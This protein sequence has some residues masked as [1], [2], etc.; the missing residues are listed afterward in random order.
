[1]LPAK[2]SPPDLPDWIVSRPRIARCIA[3]GVHDGMVTVVSGPPG[4]G[5]TV[6]LAQ[7]LRA[8]RCPGP[9]AWLTLDE[10][11]DTAGRFWW[12]V[13]AALTKSGVPL[14][15][16]MVPGD[17]DT[18][19]RIV[20]ALAAQRPPVVLVLDNLHL[21]R[22]PALDFLLSQAKPGLR[23]VAGT[24]VDHP[25]PLQR[26][27]LTW[28]ATELHG[29]QLAFTGP[30]TRLLL[31]RCGVAS[32]RESLLPLVKKTEGWAA[33]LRFVMIA[34]AGAGS[35]AGDPG[36]AERLIRGY[37]TSEVLDTQ[38]PAIRDLLLRSSFPD[39]IRP[40][41]AEALTDRADGLATLADLVQAN[42][43]LAPAENGWYRFHPLFR[44]VLQSALRESGPDMFGEVLSRTVEWF[45]RHGHLADAVRYAASTGDGQLATQVTIDE[46]AVS[47]LLDPGQ[48]RDL[49]CALQDVA[50]PSAPVR[51]REYVSAAAIALL[52]HDHAAAASWLARAD[53]ALRGLASDQEVPAQLAAEAVRTSLARSNGDLD[54]LHAA[55]VA[56]QA[57]IDRL[58]PDAVDRH[59][60]LVVQGRSCYGYAALL[61]GRFDEASK[62]L[63]EA[64]AQPLPEAAAGD[65]A[66]C[67]GHLAL[68]EALSGHLGRALELAAQSANTGARPG[69][70][71][72]FPEPPQNLSADIA[73]ALAHLE[74]H[75]VPAV[76]AAL[77]RVKT[78]LGTRRDRAAA[79]LASVI[80]A[81]LYLAEGHPGVALGLLA[82]ARQNWSPPDWLNSQIALAEARAEVMAGNPQAALDAVDRCAGVPGID[83]A[84]ARA[85]A[86]V[87]AGNM[88]AARRELRYVFEVIAAAPP[89]PPNRAVLDAL[90]VDAWIRY[91]SGDRA[92][93]RASLRRALRVAR[94]ADV[95]LPFALE[96]SWLY[97]VLRADPELAR[98]YAALARSG[99]PGRV[100]GAGLRP[101]TDSPA[102]VLAEP[103][104]E[105]EREVLQRVAQLLSTAEIA[106][107]L[108]ISVNTVK[109]HLKSIHRK[110]TVTDRRGAVRR[111]RE[112]RLL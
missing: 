76:Q 69:S 99:G 87:S 29:S 108:F 66:V 95:R 7:W 1:M 65:R 40:D 2:V 48:G 33:G 103:L 111:A 41:L 96:H 110:L 23:L 54:T 16:D 22:A 88:P 107:E 104:T 30:E 17:P 82:S 38:P 4:S 37:L 81:R 90:L 11:D 60:E 62:V 32:Y 73:L 85:H 106:G 46:L 15:A 83:V 45:R 10:Y 55:A 94:D 5:K 28:N 39:L 25:L 57:V 50:V 72:A 98:K 49:A 80:A 78:G 105:R 34:L 3:K 101:L 70:T 19:L 92:G 35:Q 8:A 63:T 112:L 59:P 102:S 18:P 20:S 26:H 84:T 109:T 42:L 21:L 58:P 86:W 9:A 13:A 27:L 67:L 52:R 75:D 79:A 97:P 47:R 14:P 6:A 74:R 56:Q 100:D 31:H 61:L 77:K 53:S 51:P 89:R 71:D 64:A 93:G 44:K 36:S 91:A 68:A 24:R 12:S 43:F